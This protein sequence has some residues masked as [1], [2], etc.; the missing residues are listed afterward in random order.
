[1]T[2][3]LRLPTV[4]TCKWRKR[5]GE[6][7]RC[8]LVS[9]I[10]GVETGPEVSDQACAACCETFP[11]TEKKLN[12]VVAGL[13]FDF[14]DQI[15]DSHRRTE[16][17]LRARRAIPLVARD[18]ITL[19]PRRAVSTCC[20]LGDAMNEV[21]SSG[22]ATYICKHS[23]HSQTTESNCRRCVD[24]SHQPPISP[25]IPLSQLVPPS[26]QKRGR[27]KRWAVGVTTSPRAD[28]TLELCLDSLQ[29]A[30]W[31]QVRLFLDGTVRVPESY[32][33]LPTS[34][35]EEPIGAWPAWYLSLAE[36]VLQQPDADAYLIIQDDVWMHDIEPLRDY[37]EDALWPG[38]GIVSL[39]YTGTEA[40][41]G[42]HCADGDWAWGAQAFVFPPELARAL[43]TDPIV[44][45]ASYSPQEQRHTPI[46]ETLFEWTDRNGI[47]VWYPRPSLT[48]HIGNTST[49]WRDAAITGGR[50]AHWYSA[51]IETPFAAE[52]ELFEFP[53]HLFQ[54]PVEVRKGYEERVCAGYERMAESRVVLCGLCRDVRPFIARTAARVER[55]GE[56]FLD[57]NV[58][59][60]END[61]VDGSRR[62]LSDWRSAN[63]RVDYIA[64]ETGIQRFPQVRSLRRAKWMADCRNRVRDRVLEKHG[65]AN[66]VIVFDADLAGGWSYDGV[67]H[68][69]GGTEWDAVGSYGVLWAPGAAE[70]R[71][72]DVW[73]FRP[74]KN[75]AARK[76]IDH[77][78]L[79][80]GRGE[81]LLPVESSFGGL[82]IYRMECLR[83]AEYG[84]EDCEHVVFHD[85]LR[86]KGLNRI[87][88]NP[89][90]IVLYSA[91]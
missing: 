58:V 15:D 37:L 19:T 47:D 24:W 65:D 45:N 31:Q 33:R 79:Q 9:S 78:K 35:R 52:H 66:F 6:S 82:S 34:W 44:A 28:S 5:S 21:D 30:G 70:L 53:E 39:F 83:A 84:G 16:L 81:P 12:S 76:M 63:P 71:H 36:L 43:L 11:P 74:A 61:S 59:L 23:Q 48:Q 3:K 75:T 26:A 89:N 67:A 88:L 14:S 1:M 87:F 29:R 46:P 2:E 68:T 25:P 18:S 91:Y 56:R 40:V 13:L 69:F 41:A 50:R 72:Y 55:L 20:F 22:Q 42:W 54:A 32:G 90:Q 64:E 10:T 62:F 80:L 73:A 51:G 49:I 7:F 4:E 57:Y 77:S 60:F 8:G 27:V 17:R 85:R 86:E 38:E